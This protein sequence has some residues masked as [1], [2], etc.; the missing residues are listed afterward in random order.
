MVMDKNF[1][2]FY[3]DTCGVELGDESLQVFLDQEAISGL[4]VNDAFMDVNVGKNSKDGGLLNFLD[5]NLVSNGRDGETVVGQ[6]QITENVNAVT[7]PSFPYPDSNNG[8]GVDGGSLEDRSELAFPP[9]QSDPGLNVVAPSSEGDGLEDYDFSDVVLTFISQMLMEEEMGEKACMFQESAALQAAERSLYE[10][11]G[12][13]YPS[14]LDQNG[15]NG[16]S[17][18]VQPN[19]DPDS[20]E[21]ENSTGQIAP[22]GV[23][24]RTNSQSSYS[25]SSSSGTA[26]D[27]HLDS[28]VSTLRIPDVHVDSPLTTLRIPEIF[29]STESIM[30]FNKGVEEASKFLP[31][32][33]GFLVDVGYIG[34]EKDNENQVSR[35]GSRRKKNLHYEGEDL[36]EGRSYKQ[37]AVSSESTVILE[38]FDKVLLCSGGKNESALRQSW[39]NVSSKK[40]MDNDLPKGSTGK[41]S[42]GRK[43]SKSEVVDLR[44]ILTLCAQA[45][46]ADDRRTAHEFL[47]QIRQHSSQ[48]G[49]GMQRLAHYFADGLEARMAGSGTQIYK[50]LISMPTSA[51]DVLKAYQLYLAACPF[52]KI[53][54]FFSNKTI[55]NVA[56]DAKSVHIID[57]GILYGFQWPCFIQRLSSRPGGPPKLRITGID[58]PQPGF[59][60]A[61]RIEET[62]QR[63]ANY[64][65]RFNVPFEFNAIAQNWETVKIE[66][67]GINGDEVVVVNCLYRFRN[68]LDETVVVDSPRD[69]VLS[70]IRE[71]NPAVFITGSVNGAYNAPFFISRFREALFHYSALFDMLEAN[72]PREIHERVLLE[73]TIFGREAMNVIACEGAERIE[74]PEIYKQCQIRYT[75]AGFRQLPL[76]DEIMQMS[77]HRVKAY[78]KDFIIDQDGKWLLQGWKGRIVYALSTWKAAY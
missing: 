18:L 61:E 48:T 7:P 24:L 36:D 30:Q 4:S 63:L 12:E 44:T 69:I 54:N 57:F 35:E 42:R 60:P 55:M 52:R 51:A 45:V 64:A 26:N 47:K 31:N 28:P 67:L 38:M 74:R 72:I 39:Q 11:I 59:R 1:G 62:G 23:T 3:Q 27:G 9:L 21:C 20:I 50:A 33:N 10:V 14:A 73:K 6:N 16:D 37:S 56:K 46:A 70:L 68:L 77:R 58:F 17:G 76:N 65:E 13:E 25:S 2:G 40:A 53:S 8:L 43:G 15:N 34:L 71:L 49:D 29:N 75:R 32:A 66:D 19:W 5:P 22:V 41:K 78:H